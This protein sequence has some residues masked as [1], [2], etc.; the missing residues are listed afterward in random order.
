MNEGEAGRPGHSIPPPGSL[1]DLDDAFASLNLL[2]E[3]AAFLDA[4]RLVRRLA[5]SEAPV[6]LCGETGTGKELAAR[7]IHYLSPRRPGP[8]IPV[9]CGAIP[10]GLVESELFGHA[11]GAFTDAREPRDGFVAQAADG[12]LFLDELETL[13]PRGQVALLRF[14]QDQEYRPVGGERLLIA[15]VRVVGSTNVDLGALVRRGIYREDLVYRLSV[16]TI[17]LP[18]LRERGNDV[19]LL[20]AAFLNRLCGRYRSAPVHLHPDSVARL[21]SQRWPGNV[22]ELENLIHRAFLLCEESELRLPLD[23][24]A[25]GAGPARHEAGLTDR[26]FREAK[27]SA[28]CAFERAYLA[29]LLRRANG[30]VSLAA[31]LAGKERSRLGKLL[32]KHGLTRGA[33][34][35]H[36]LS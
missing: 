11:R 30:N 7:A 17:L 33:D 35:R 24:P 29:E 28:I 20:A 13:S 22:R 2:G 9:N 15:N 10:D 4:L 21:L 5:P 31:R 16:L 14:L 34:R 26:S 27:A 32:R 1:I 25:A 18:P 3:S 8:F 19:V 6:L 36:A 23:P 12:T